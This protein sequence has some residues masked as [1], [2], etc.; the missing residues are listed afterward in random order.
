MHV[1]IE[2]SHLLRKKLFCS[3][4]SLLHQCNDCKDTDNKL[5]NARRK[6]ESSRNVCFRLRDIWKHSMAF[7][8]LISDRIVCTVNTVFTL[9]YWLLIRIIFAFVIDVQ[10]DQILCT[11]SQI[12]KLETKSQSKVQGPDPK[13]VQLITLKSSDSIIMHRIRKKWL[14]KYV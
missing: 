9:Q 2:K 12:D 3:H 13:R 10:T 5:C 11:L 14:P 1:S 8:E 7:R 4:L 6:R